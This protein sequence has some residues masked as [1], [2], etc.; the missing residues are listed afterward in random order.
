MLVTI[1]VARYRL[2]W[3]LVV[4]Y[5]TLRKVAEVMLF[6]DQDIPEYSYDNLSITICQWPNDLS[7]ILVYG[8][9]LEKEADVG[10]LGNTSNRRCYLTI[11]A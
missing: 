11:T 8:C 1:F 6:G 5:A 9:S 4:P 2:H 7:K 10:C 3:W